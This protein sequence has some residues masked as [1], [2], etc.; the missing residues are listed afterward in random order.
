M[1][2]LVSKYITILLFLFFPYFIVAQQSFLSK[3]ITVHAKDKPVR[4]ILESISDQSGIHF[5][6]NSSAVNDEDL[7]SFEVE[8]KT[9]AET[10]DRLSEQLGIE[11]KLIESQV[12]LKKAKKKK[13]EQL[14]FTISGY[15]RDQTTSESLPGATVRIDSTVTGTISN[16]YGF[17]SLTLPLGSYTLLY[18][19]IG[20]QSQRYTIELEVDMTLDTRM[21]FVIS[22]LGEVTITSDQRAEDLEKSQMSRIRFNPQ[23]LA[24]L[25]QFAGESG[26]VKSLQTIPGIKTHS[27]GSAFFFVRGGNKDQNLILI[28]E[29]PIYNPAHLF[30]YY[31]VIIPEVSK[32]ISIYKGDMP[33]NKGDRISSVIDIQTKDGNMNRFELNGLLN[34]LLYRFSLEGP[35]VKEKASFFTSFRHSNFAWLYRWQ[36]PDGD[37]NFY[38]FNAKVNLILNKNNRI[39]WA[40]F[41]GKDNLVNNAA[42]E[43]GGIKWS[44]LTTT[45]RW[46]HI[47]NQKLFLNTTAYASTYNYTLLTRATRWES[48]I[49]NL[50]LNVDFTYY[51]T[52][53]SSYIF[54]FD[55]SVHF[56][57]PG[58]LTIDNAAGIIPRV[59][60]TQSV[61]SVFYVSNERTVSRRWSFKLGL[62]MPVWTNIGP[63][64]VY[65]FDSAYHVTDVLEIQKNESYKTFVNLDPRISL[66]YRIDTASSLKLS[67]GIYHQHIQ[68]LSNS[69]SPF[70]SFEI[71][72]PAG[73]NI[74]PQRADQ[75]A[76]GYSRFL[77][78]AG[79]ELSAEAF[80][81]L[82]QHQIEYEPHASLL[83]NPLIEGELRFGKARSY[84]IELFIR[85]TRGR[86]SGRISYSW[87]RA[88][89]TFDAINGGKEYPAFYD[90]PH[91]VSIVLSYQLSQRLLFS[92]N[93]VYYT[94]SAIT[95]P[96]G[97][98]DY[99][100]NTVPL[101][102]DKNNDRLPDY[103]RLDVALDWR[104]NKKERKYQH[105]L[106]F[107]IYNF[108]NRRNPVSINFNKIE[109]KDGKFVVPA[110]I[111]GTSDIVTTQRYLLGIMPSIT[112][113][114]RL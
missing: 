97:F 81:K 17:Y 93:W 83:L 60:E 53:K 56:F 76:L 12:V 104:L 23:N 66:T 45:F 68:L 1:K 73:T 108:Y 10:L 28:D 44:N 99:N 114:F 35:I 25:P 78:R 55:Q 13:E 22:D 67:Y 52:P 63:T 24:T 88:L 47:F 38:D 42:Y 57:N 74:R 110:N 2:L 48:D 69:I 46:N 64:T 15:I 92:T 89:Q 3:K 62:R 20:Y 113:E 85:R 14:L 9:L 65:L 8:N 26:L 49:G 21:E 95:T 79:I 106:T 98:Y 36:V 111:F 86:L 94:G 103:H 43:F 58:N 5:S 27:D 7:I 41:L 70:S 96:I 72:L 29:A 34:P 84:G 82:M 37:F 31:S 105:N 90:R 32:N 40:F 101:Y 107:S 4:D 18:S 33:I 54:G 6:Y 51:H 100:G 112:Y 77:S 91:D 39:F 87:S 75:A 16:P 11:W 50:S 19:Y 80:Y 59:A 109:T 61:K 71:W 102:G 30:G